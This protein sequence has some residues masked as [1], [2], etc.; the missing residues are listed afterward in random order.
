M[1]IAESGF[2]Q[3]E[4]KTGDILFRGKKPTD[5]SDAID[6]VTQTGKGHHFSHVGMVEVIN[7]D[8]FVFHAEGEKGV[9]KEPLDSFATDEAGRRLYVEAYRLKP[10]YQNN[11]DSAILRVK[12]VIGEPYNYTYIIEDKG[13]Y[14]SE[15]IY[16]AF[17]SDSVFQLNPM[18]FKDLE[19]DEF[20]PG[21]IEHYDKLEI[22]IPEGLPG[23]NPNGMAASE[24]LMHIGEVE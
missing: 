24:N 13:Y 12:S 22:E 23:C 4:L 20:H 9:C 19:T 11:I 6:D 8:V 14:C 21:W 1:F 16:W 5:L 18:T 2:G 15:L 17:E 3:I 10:G 7:S